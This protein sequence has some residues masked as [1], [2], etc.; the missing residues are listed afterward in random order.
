MVLGVFLRALEN[1]LGV[2]GVHRGHL[3]NKGPCPASETVFFLT[4][5]VWART[6]FPWMLFSFWQRR[7]SRV[8]MLLSFTSGIS[9]WEL[10]PKYVV[11]LGDGSINGYCFTVYL[12]VNQNQWKMTFLLLVFCLKHKTWLN[13]VMDSLLEVFLIDLFVYKLIC[14]CHIS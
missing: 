14:R 12:W 6:V 8:R 4:S 9:A 11:S 2:G 1:L 7:S 5:T 3:G 10:L 13:H